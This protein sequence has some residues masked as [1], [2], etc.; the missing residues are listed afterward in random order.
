MELE[1][2]RV[3]YTLVGITAPQTMRLLPS[4]G[5]RMMQKVTVYFKW[6]DQIMYYRLFNDTKSTAIITE[7]AFSEFERTGRKQSISR[8]CF[9]IHQ[10]EQE[11]HKRLQL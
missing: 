5:T 6:L 9:S 4:I 2:S 1:L 10:K 7:L 3:D 8:Y 11:D